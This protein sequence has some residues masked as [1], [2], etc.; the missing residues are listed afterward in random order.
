MPRQSHSCLGTNLQ[1]HVSPAHR[2]TRALYGLGMKL[3]PHNE[4]RPPRAPC[5]RSGASQYSAFRFFSLILR[6]WLLRAWLL[7]AWLLRALVSAVVAAKVH[8]SCL[9]LPA[10]SRLQP[11]QGCFAASAERFYTCYKNV[12]LLSW[13][14]PWSLRDFL[15]QVSDQDLPLLLR[16]GMD[17]LTG[18]I[19]SLAHV[20]HIAA[21]VWCIMLM[22]RW[23]TSQ[24]W[25]CCSRTGIA[26]Q[27]SWI[28]DF[29]TILWKKHL[30]RVLSAGYNIVNPT[31]QACDAPVETHSLQFQ[32]LLYIYCSGLSMIHS[33]KGACMI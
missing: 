25:Y 11:S 19:S 18:T 4:P 2:W 31:I 8:R 1:P 16:D 6:N 13:L 30:E 29:F 10:V 7:S 9:L 23:Q 20:P 33:F 22:M 28:T 14:W 12:T 24:P 5:T 3:Q 17:L 15:G 26:V 21:I 27:W 32:H